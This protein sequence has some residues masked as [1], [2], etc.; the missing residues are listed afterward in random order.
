M[1][2][3]DALLAS[4]QQQ[5]RHVVGILGGLPEPAWRQAFLPSGWTA[6]AL[7]GHLTHDVERFWFEAVVAGDP[8]TIAA[9]GDGVDGW[10]VSAD[11]DPADVLAAYV[12]AGERA[13]AILA[14]APADA[15]PAWWPSFFGDWRLADV[16]EVELHVLTE[17]ACHAGHL[18]AVRELADGRQWLV[19]G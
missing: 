8:A 17:T 18:D 14:A 5:R 3:H 6:L 11:A 12:A 7:V 13:D 19:L 4:L 10:A 1:T 16:Q 9:I 15:P 2:H